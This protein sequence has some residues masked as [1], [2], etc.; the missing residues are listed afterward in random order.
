MYPVFYTYLVQSLLS[1][2]LPHL[3][4][5]TTFPCFSCLHCCSCE[6]KRKRQ[7]M[8]AQGKD[9]TLQAFI[10]AFSG[11]SKGDKVGFFQENLP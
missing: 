4:F 1:Y 10:L 9:Q 5:G 7:G 11:C 6:G 3:I 8:K 2:I